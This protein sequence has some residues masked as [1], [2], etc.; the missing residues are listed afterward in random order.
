MGQFEPVIVTANHG[1]RGIL[2]EVVRTPGTNE[3]QALVQF[4][5]GQEIRVP[6]FTLIWREDGTC[7]LPMSLDEPGQEREHDPG[8]GQDREAI[9]LPVIR[10]EL[11]IGKR[12]VETG[13][14]RIRKVVREREELVE[15]S[16]LH[17]KVHVERVPVN[18]VLDE[19]VGVRHQGDTMII[20]VLEEVLVLEKRLVLKEE[21]HVT[22]ELVSKIEAQ[23]ITLRSEDVL[24]E[25]IDPKERPAD[26][27][28]DGQTQGR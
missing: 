4:G 7:H 18:R 27:G 16:L 6:I 28:S 11:D 1:Q 24:V 19:P 21:L 26:G 20:P 14:V 2:A 3:P 23:R 10:E 9:V 8:A 17:E 12:M 22:R 15:Q 5:N 25:R 13:G